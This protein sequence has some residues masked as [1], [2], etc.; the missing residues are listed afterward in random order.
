MTFAHGKGFRWRG[1]AVPLLAALVSPLAAMA[2]E[3]SAAEARMAELT[4]RLE[5][6]QRKIA[7]LE[8]R[9]NT[10]AN[11]DTEK[12]RTD[13][14]RAQIRSILA[15]GEFRESLMPST[16]LSGYDKG[17]YINSSDGNFSFKVNGQ[18]QFRFTHYG[19]RSE[20][21]YLLPRTRRDDRTGF[22]ITRLR[23]AFSGHAHEPAL[24]YFFAISQDQGNA[25][26]TRLLYGWM[27]YKFS[28]EFQV[29]L[30]RYTLAA[31]RTRMAADSQQQFVDRSMTDAYYSLGDGT[32]VRF[33]GQC[34]N[35]RVEWF[36]DIHNS[37]NG[38]DNRVITNDPSELDGN[39]AIVGRVIWHALGDDTSQYW[40]EGDID[41]LQDPYLGIGMHAA[42]NE[43][44]GDRQTTRI[45]FNRSGLFPFFR[46]GGYGLAPLNG[47][48]LWQMGA[49]AM[50][51][52]QGFS[53]SGEYFLRFVD[54]RQAWDRPFAP[55]WRLTGEE[56]TTNSMGAFVQA[57]YFL[58]IPEHEKKFEAVARIGGM[59]TNVGGGEG[60][61]EYSVG[62]NYYIKGHWMKLQTDV[63]KIYEMPI[64]DSDSSL[65]NVNDDG[66]IWRV[67]MQVL[68]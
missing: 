10:A 34:A 8:S 68:F 37:T 62:L 32:G 57:G 53:L 52:W 36:L 1:V 21:R 6:Q 25:Y 27:N 49:D 58:P 5:E 61:W 33:W 66:L 39:P 15:D 50:F 45:A 65:A 16:L 2:V 30:G 38:P 46:P 14:L 26:D 59:R 31:G 64:S 12:A 24:T 40:F 18:L 29:K 13:A 3:P 48:R 9:A 47:A 22:D 20:N 44:D 51:K 4:A 55:L 60:S 11:Q 54:I 7:E 17:F 63:T 56:S 67:Q 43:D 35:K 19:T 28:D 23:F 41:H 42:F